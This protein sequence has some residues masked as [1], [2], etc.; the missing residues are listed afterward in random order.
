MNPFNKRWQNMNGG[1]LYTIIGSFY[2]VLSLRYWMSPYNLIHTNPGLE[3][4]GLEIASKYGLLAPAANSPFCLKQ[5]LIKTPETISQNELS[6]LLKKQ[7]LQFPLIAKPDYGCAGFGVKLINGPYSLL[8]FF[9]KISAP[10]LLQEFC[11]QPV[12]FGVYYKRIPGEETGKVISL[13]EKYIPTVT[14]DAIHTIQQLIH[15]SDYSSNEKSKLLKHCENLQSIPRDNEVVNVIVQGSHARGAV[16][17]DISSKITPTLNKWVDELSQQ[18]PHFYY[19]RFD[20]KAA[21]VTDL[22]NGTDAKVIELN[23]AM[24]EP[25]HVYDDHCSFFIGM[26]TFFQYNSQAF[27]I[28]KLNIKT[29]KLPPPPKRKI[30]RLFFKFF[31]NKK[32]LEEIK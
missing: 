32:V 31:A 4:G 7:D 16:F 28:A 24:S 10:Y 19:G 6:L 13:T 3:Y 22:L 21:S 15:A 8:Q 11:D 25:I 2:A 17:K 29:L 27:Q 26:C 18:I 1:L 9:S 20:I 14:G 5:A 30:T 23:G 12:E